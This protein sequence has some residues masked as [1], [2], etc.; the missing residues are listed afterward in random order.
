M[1]KLPVWA[2]VAAGMA[3]GA[4]AGAALRMCCREKSAAHRLIQKAKNAL[5]AIESKLM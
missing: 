4:A 3:A 1:K 2:S 5:T